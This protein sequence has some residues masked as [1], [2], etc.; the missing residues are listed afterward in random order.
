MSV[1]ETGRMDGFAEANLLL[2]SAL[3]QLDD[4]IKNGNNRNGIV[5]GEKG[6]YR[7]TPP[8]PPPP[9]SI[10]PILLRPSNFGARSKIMENGQAH[11][12]HDKIIEHIDDDIDNGNADDERSTKEV[13]TRQWVTSDWKHRT[14]LGS[15]GSS[16]VESPPSDLP[17][18]SSSLFN[19]P[20][21]YQ[22]FVKA[23]DEHMI[24]D[25]PDLETRLKIMQWVAGRT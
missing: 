13:V 20:R 18:S 22:D 11:I 7:E 24:T 2:T 3:E 17:T 4:I 9:V 23:I 14:E 16:G 6:R 25:R 8:P 19:P 21:I 15:D 1:I 5:V 10:P 12:H